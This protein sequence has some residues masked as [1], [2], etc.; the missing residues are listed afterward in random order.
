M[1]EISPRAC[2]G[3]C[4]KRLTNRFN[5]AFTLIELIVVI[6]YHYPY[7]VSSEHSWLRAEKGRPRPRRDG[8]RRNVRR[9]RKLQGG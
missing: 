8:N 9:L 4:A 6:N 5:G 7:G 2:R 1:N 3:V